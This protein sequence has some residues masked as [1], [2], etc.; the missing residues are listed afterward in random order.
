MDKQVHKRH[1]RIVAQDIIGAAADDDARLARRDRAD[2][3]R[4]CLKDLHRKRLLVRNDAAARHERIQKAARTL[5]LMRLDKAL[6][7]AARFCGLIDEL[8]II[9][10]DAQRLRQLAAELT[11]SLPIVITRL[12][13][14]R[15]PS[16]FICR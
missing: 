12:A 10:L 11:F 15:S 9:A 5:L 7:K 8:R 2:D 13:I 14:V 16:V 4:L 1:V 6:G 3:L